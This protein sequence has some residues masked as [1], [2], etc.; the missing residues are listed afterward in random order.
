MGRPV[1]LISCPNCLPMRRGLHA[2]SDAWVAVVPRGQAIH[3]RFERWLRLPRGVLSHEAV[4]QSL[5]FSMQ[6]S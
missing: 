4:G 2:P 1:S 5:P 3:D 6:D